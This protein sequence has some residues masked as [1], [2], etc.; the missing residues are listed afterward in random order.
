MKK[1]VNYFI[2]IV[3]LIVIAVLA[4]SFW[5][6]KQVVIVNS[7]EDCVAAGYPVMES[8]PRQCRANDQTFVEDIGNELAKADLIRI[9]YPRPNQ[10]I[11]SPLEITGQ[12][13]GTWYFEA[14]FPVELRDANG[15]LLIQ[16]YAQAQ[17]EWMT[18][19]FVPFKS[20]LEFT[21]P[22]TPTGQLILRKDN[23]SGLPEHDDQLIVPIKF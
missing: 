19:D 4:V 12:A 6:K 9:D 7:F 8:Y 22:S 14:S 5:P 21:K 3:I 1:I 11:T 13:R 2:L 23:P 18:A 20:I 15:N 10:T 16:Y 17:G